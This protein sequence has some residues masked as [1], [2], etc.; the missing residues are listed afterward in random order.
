MAFPFSFSF[1]V[2]FNGLNFIMILLLCSAAQTKGSGSGAGAGAGSGSGSGLVLLLDN[3]DHSYFRTQSLSQEAYMTQSDIAAT[4]SVLLG[5]APSASLS[6]SSSKLDALLTPN[7]FKRPHAVLVL[8]A[9]GINQETL[10]GLDFSNFG[11]ESYSYRHL[12][13]ESSDTAF[14]FPEDE[15]MLVSLK[16]ASDDEND[17]HSIEKE[18]SDLALWLGGFY[19]GG[20]QPMQGN[21]SIPLSKESSLTL[22]LLKG[23]DQIFAKELVSLYQNIRRVAVMHENLAES[24]LD[25]AELLLGSF[26][27]VE[28]L[29]EHYGHNNIPCKGL[30]LFL[31]VAVKLFN[32][33]QLSYGGQI[34]GIVAMNSNVVP[35]SEEM[36]DIKLT[37]RNSHLLSELDSSKRLPPNFAEVQAKLIRKA[38]AWS[39]AFIL[40]VTTL[41]GVYYLFNM[42]I[43]RDT[44]LYSNVKLD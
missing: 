4:M 41:V 17:L 40:L 23:A 12:V 20:Q 21:L 31:N 3:P 22:N 1:T 34:V 11:L 10:S 24:S 19:T 2:I 16:G 38:V 8:E 6:V 9:R 5:F 44:L 26:A 43:T 18:L 32:S 25:T 37:S 27:G 42:P 30:E 15:V 29:Q 33:L 36:F 35:S 28:A 39:M 14:D 13:A 7:P